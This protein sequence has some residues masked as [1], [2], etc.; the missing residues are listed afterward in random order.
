MRGRAH[1]MSLKKFFQK[2]CSGLGIITT[3]ATYVGLLVG[4]DYL[5]TKY[6]DGPMVSAIVWSASV[7]FAIYAFVGLLIYCWFTHLLLFCANGL[8][9]RGRSFESRK[10]ATREPDT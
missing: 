8:A 10:G 9:R 6:W 7:A 2:K 4:L 5:Y 1:I 3:L